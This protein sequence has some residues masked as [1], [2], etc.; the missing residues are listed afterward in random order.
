MFY[1][2]G[3]ILEEVF[4]IVEKFAQRDFA[5]TSTNTVTTRFGLKTLEL[6]LRF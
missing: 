1:I 6:Q 2:K 4:F 5:Q 3:L